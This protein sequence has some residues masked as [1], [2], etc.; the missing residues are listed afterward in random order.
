MEEKFIT[1]T[2]RV[3]TENE[4][5]VIM[6]KT[7]FYIV[8]GHQCWTNHTFIVKAPVSYPVPCVGCL[9]S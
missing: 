7:G 6:Q 5:H 1:R 8:E 2:K 9:E 3:Q 4:G